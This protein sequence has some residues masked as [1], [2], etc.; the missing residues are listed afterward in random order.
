MKARHLKKIQEGKAESLDDERATVYYTRGYDLL[1]RSD[2]E[3]LDYILLT[4][5]YLSD[6]LTRI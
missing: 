6:D 1:N 5:A 3:H 4:L 2:R